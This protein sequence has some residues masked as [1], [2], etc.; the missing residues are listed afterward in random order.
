MSHELRTPLT[1]I[2][3]FSEL[4]KE[5]LQESGNVQL[6]DDAARIHRSG[7]HLLGLINEIL[8]LS[9]IEAGKMELVIEPLDA[10]AV[11]KPWDAL[12]PLIEAR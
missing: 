4:L 9:K 1:A 7:S 3:G 2:I 12:S 8:D 10:E 6:Y 11:V 5:D